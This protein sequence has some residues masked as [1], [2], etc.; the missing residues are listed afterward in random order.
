MTDD[1]ILAKLT[2]IFQDILDDDDIVLT[3]ATTANDIKDWDSANHINLVV[4]TEM[5]FNVK[6]TNVDI[7]QLKN[8]GD[9]VALIQ[10]KLAAKG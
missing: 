8:V 4:S 10:K 9:F 1:D 2:E 5:R 6:F 3:P 7:E